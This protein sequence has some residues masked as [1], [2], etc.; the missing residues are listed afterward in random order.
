M[1]LQPSDTTSAPACAAMLRAIELD[2]ARLA[3]LPFARAAASSAPLAPGPDGLLVHG[4]DAE[5]LAADSAARA[6]ERALG[7][8][9]EPRQALVLA[10][11]GRPSDLALAR[12]RNALWPWLHA[13]AIVRSLDGRLER[14]LLAGREPLEPGEPRAAGEPDRD[15]TLFALRRRDQ[16]LSPA[17]TVTKFDA[18]ASGWNGRPGS[19]GYPHYRWMRRFVAHYPAALPRRRILDFGCGAGWVGIEAALRSPG[20]HLAFFD[21]SPEMV[22]HAADNAAAEGLAGAEGRTGFGEDPPFPAPGEAPFDLVLSSGVV[23]FSPDFE[24]WFDGL[25]RC[26]APGGTLVVGDIHR[27]GKGFV[28]R[29]RTKPLLPIRE[30]NALVPA[31]VQSALGARG[32]RFVR[33]SGYQLTWPVPQAMHFSEARMG[34]L[35]SGP[36]LFANRVAAGLERRRASL[37]GLFDSWVL[38]FER[39]A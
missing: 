30:L 33:G 10:F 5:R 17:V 20:A 13:G 21:P 29:R 25:A 4:L 2:P 27:A 3:A 8:S 39:P 37:S 19:P 7:G 28:R 6:L 9:L 15:A 26:V 16:A 38:E 34:G 23:S 36:L 18:N 24:R 12:W 14:E 11:E 32:L 31:E 35:L 1:D 22:R